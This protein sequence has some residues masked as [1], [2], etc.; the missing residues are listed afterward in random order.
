MTTAPQASGTSH[1]W[2]ADSYAF[3][4]GGNTPLDEADASS[5]IGVCFGR[6]QSP[7]IASAKTTGRA[8]IEFCAV[9]INGQR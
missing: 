7:Q 2:A 4:A 8:V 3:G 9:N 5:T 6:R 1:C